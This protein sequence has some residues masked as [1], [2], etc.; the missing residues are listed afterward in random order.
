MTRA[1]EGDPGAGRI[2]AASAAPIHG[3]DVS[4]ASR[5]DRVDQVPLAHL[6]A[7]GD[8]FLLRDLVERLAV[9][10]LQRVTGPA[11]ALAPARSLLAQAAP[12]GRREVGDRSLPLR[13]LLRLLDVALRGLD[14]LP[15]CHGSHLRAS[16][17]ERPTRFGADL[18]LQTRR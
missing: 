15:R 13:R 7:A 3:K 10:V 16:F 12:S 4:S 1:T 14:L 9:A 11:A 18:H 8:A 17:R 2:G 5:A 6:R